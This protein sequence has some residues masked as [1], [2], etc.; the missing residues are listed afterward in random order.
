[1][2]DGDTA[3]LFLF[4]SGNSSQLV[5]ARGRAVAELDL[6]SLEEPDVVNAIYER[7]MSVLQK[8]DAVSESLLEAVMWVAHSE[9]S[10]DLFERPSPSSRVFAAAPNLVPLLDESG[11]V[12]V[13]GLDARPW[14]L[15]TGDYAFHYHQFL[16]RNFGSNIHYELIGTVLGL[17]R[18]YDLVARLAL[19]ERRI[20]F[21]ES[22]E[23]WEERDHWYGPGL[24]DDNLDDL[25]SVGETFHGDPDL[26]LSWMHPYAGLSV[27]W[28][29][30][31]PLKGVE[32][33]EFMPPP[34]PGAEWVLARYLHAIRDTEKKAFIHCDGAVKAFAADRYPTSQQDFR[35][36]GK[37]DRYRKLFRVDGAFPATAWSEI[38]C[39]WFRGN[40]LILEYFSQAT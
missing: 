31:G 9:P 7:L 20:R 6:W 38:A 39:S 15:H 13:N 32:I 29:A 1:M 8:P 35:T 25:L 36:R 17:A 37:G 34:K 19:D 14:G 23:E 5:E 22:Y 33:E 12:S 2:L 3:P 21:R 26:G 10:V 4:S 11:L 28:T 30:D 27:R 18:Q 16:R 40:K 24:V